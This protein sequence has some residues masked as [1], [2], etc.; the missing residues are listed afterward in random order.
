MQHLESSK[1]DNWQAVAE[2]VYNQIQDLIIKIWGS[3]I[4]ST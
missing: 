4:E 1:I 2:K 3:N